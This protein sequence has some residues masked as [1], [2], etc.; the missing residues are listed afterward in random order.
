MKPDTQKRILPGEHSVPWRANK[1]EGGEKTKQK[2]PRCVHISFKVVAFLGHYNVNS[3]VNSP[4]TV[5]P[6][7]ATLTLVQK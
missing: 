7:S 3:Y 4:K 2:E 5:S 6:L 1:C